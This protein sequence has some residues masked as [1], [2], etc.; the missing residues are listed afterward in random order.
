LKSQLNR[1]KTNWI[2]EKPIE[3]LKSQLNCWKA[4]WI[5]EKPIESLKSQLSRWK[6]K[7]VVKSPK[8]IVSL[9]FLSDM[10]KCK[11]YIIKKRR[12]PLKIKA[13][14]NISYMLCSLRFTQHIPLALWAIKITRILVKKKERTKIKKFVFDQNCTF[15]AKNKQQ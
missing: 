2:V 4:N 6:R 3:L 8:V 13:V 12:F 9:L 11:L 15:Y 10:S 14:A 1:W 7:I 5:V